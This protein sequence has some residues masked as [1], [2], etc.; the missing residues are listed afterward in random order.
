MGRNLSNHSQSPIRGRGS[1]HR[2]SPSRRERSPA[3]RHRS[4]H[5]D[6]SSAREKRSTR[7]KSPKHEMSHS[8]L[9]ARHR[10]S[11]RDSSPQARE[12]NYSPE[13]SR[14][15]SPRTKRLR[16]A[17]A[18]RETE[19]VV[20]RDRER[21]H[22]K[23]D[24]KGMHRERETEKLFERERE[25][26]HGKGSDK[27]ARREREAEILTEREYE[28]N[29]GRVTDKNTH[30][31]R[32]E[33]RD[34]AE[35]MERRSGRDATDG[36]S[37]RARNGLSTSPSDH[38]H[39]SKHRSRSPLRDAHRR[40]RDEV[41][42]SRG[43]ERRSDVDD[44]VAKMKAAEE[45]LEAK[46]KQQPSFELSGKLAAE[47][48]RVRGVTLLFNEPPDARKPDIR[49]RLYVFKNG[50]VLNEPLYIHRQTCYLFGRE[51]RVADIPTDHPSCS[52]QHAVIQFRQ[53][54][55]EQPDG[56]LSKQVRP[57]LMDLGSTNKTFINDNPIEPQR[58]YELFEKDTIKFGN[59]S[60]EY[61]LL[62]ENSAS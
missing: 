6:S 38:N 33:D 14:S 61:V 55:K 34:G 26:S 53:V 37:S 41:T 42:N 25:K 45:A 20:E 5:R 10:S 11:Q 28:K 18:D 57:Y 40:E 16:R 35:R 9:P 52:K 56:T 46:Q 22:G 21:N 12:K 44:S 29:H 51:R 15:P 32:G 13:K 1:P 43:T 17:Q 3:A 23:G 36:K 50:E 60:R 19:T 39:R 59:S 54:E 49:W 24:D 8:P 62:H 4:S 31:E 47:T 7:T 58:Y 30:R 27:S 2:K 48:N